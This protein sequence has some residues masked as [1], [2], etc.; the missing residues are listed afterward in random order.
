M[1]AIFTF[2]SDGT[3]RRKKK[4]YNYKEQH[5]VL[6]DG[7]HFSLGFS[8]LAADDARS[9]LEQS[10]D[11]LEE[12]TEVHCST[13]DNLE[14]DAIL[15]DILRKLKALMSYRAENMNCFD[16]AFHQFKTDKLGDDDASTIFL[17]L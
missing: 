12:I 16:K 15:I 10:V 7:S 4:L 14:R 6:E 1:Q 3:R 17:F 2:A 11:K 13:N 5:I 9:L 8:Q